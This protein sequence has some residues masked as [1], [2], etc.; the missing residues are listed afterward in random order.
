MVSKQNEGENF[1]EFLQFIGNKIELMNWTGYNGGLDVYR[2]KTGT[3]SI[4][5]THQDYEIMFHVST[6]LPLDTEDPNRIARKC[7]IGNDIVI[8]IFQEKGSHPLFDPCWISSYF[9]HVFIVI[10][11][12]EEASSANNNTTYRVAVCYKDGVEVCG[13]GLPANCCFE[14]GEEFKTWLLTKLINCERASY[15][16]PGFAKAL[17][18]TRCALLQSIHEEFYP[19]QSGAWGS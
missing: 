18:R 11:K 8:I 14:K 15:S 12:D 16:A 13:P 10:K 3:H 1:Q 9:N 5:T 6:Y 19:A 17:E 4:H 7:H 2:G